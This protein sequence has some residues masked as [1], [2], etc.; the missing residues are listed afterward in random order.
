MKH[1][2]LNVGNILFVG[3]V[4]VVSIIFAKSLFKAAAQSGHS[5][6]QA[7]GSAGEQII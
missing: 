4:A 1:I 2:D 5:V 7:M 3:A 6:I